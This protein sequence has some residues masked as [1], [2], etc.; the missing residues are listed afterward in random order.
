[1]VFGFRKKAKSHD[2]V[3]SGLNQ[4]SSKTGEH[5]SESSFPGDRKVQAGVTNFTSNID[6][7]KSAESPQASTLQQEPGPGPASDSMAPPES[8][9]PTYA[10]HARVTSQPRP[11]HPTESDYKAGFL[12][13]KTPNLPTDPKPEPHGYSPEE[14]AKMEK[15]GISPQLKWELDAYKREGKGKGWKGSFWTK[16]GM[17]DRIR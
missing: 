14:V 5:A 7:V 16:V 17:M 11:P 10:A 8:L 3:P 6:N 13:Q 9:P 4:P 12:W 1:M 15:E 2:T